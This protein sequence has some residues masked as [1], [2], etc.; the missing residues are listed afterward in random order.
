MKLVIL[1]WLLLM[2]TVF[3]ETLTVESEATVEGNLILLVTPPP[4]EVRPS[5]LDYSTV[6]GSRLVVRKA[7]RLGPAN[8]LTVE[9]GPMTP[10]RKVSGYLDS[11]RNFMVT[12]SC[13]PGERYSSR[14]LRWGNGRVLRLDGVQQE[15]RPPLPPWMQQHE[16]LSQ[17]LLAAGYNHNEA[18]IKMLVGLPPGY[19]QSRQRYGVLY[20][21]SGFNGDRFSYLRRYRQMRQWMEET[22]QHFILVSLD[23]SGRY[24]HHLFLDS[25]LNGPRGQVLVEEIVP[26]IDHYYRTRAEKSGRAIYGQSSGAWTAIS[27][28]RR[29]P[30][31]FGT[32]LASNPDPLQLKEWWIPDSDN[33]YTRA[34]GTPHMLTPFLQLREFIDLETVSGS[35]GQIAGFEACFGSPMFDRGTGRVNDSVWQAWQDNDLYRWVEQNPEQARRSYHRRLHLFAGE[36]DEFGLT[37][38]ATAFSELLNRL[39]IDHE[40]EL[41]RGGHHSDYVQR[42]PFLRQLWERAYRATTTGG[43]S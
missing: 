40:F 3:A 38:M 25:E 21:S 14:P 17:K 29:H 1:F 30:E 42:D 23:S 2:G 11:D 13:G 28:L 33:V 16:L 43:S 35:A 36:R 9:L 19:H 8:P 39:G 37:P 4:L 5:R 24:G 27:A 34:D 20:V 31:T 32:A 18:T 15:Q 12:M 10:G 26:T 7:V 41:I 6:I 22:G